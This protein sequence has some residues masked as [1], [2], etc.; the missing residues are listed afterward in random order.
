M[1]AKIAEALNKVSELHAALA[2]A[3]QEL[4]GHYDAESAKG[5]KQ[6][7]DGAAGAVS[8]KGKPAA[9]GQKGKTA[10]AVGDDDD[11][12]TPTAAAGK[13]KTATPAKPAGGKGKKVT[14]D[15][16][17]ASAKVLIDTYGKDAALEVLGEFNATKL[18]EVEESDY[19]ACKA[20]MEAKLEELNGGGEE[21][22]EEDDLLA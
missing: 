6:G 8:G 2:E 3:Y 10:A 22:G 15:E 12:P 4:S 5:G 1:S 16:V 17:R 21:G 19:S 9:V 18:A 11:L 20:K 7:N 14:E 13:G